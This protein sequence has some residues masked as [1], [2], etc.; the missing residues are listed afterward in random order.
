MKQVTIYTSPS[1]HFCHQAKEFFKAK[2]IAYTEYDVLADMDKRKEMVE[3]SGQMGVPVI[4]V[5]GE[6][7]TGFNQ[8]RLEKLLSL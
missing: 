8:R 2:N 1:C 7:M 4:M 3:K 6:I 5:D